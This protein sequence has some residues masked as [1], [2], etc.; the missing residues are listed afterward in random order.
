MRTK[1]FFDLGVEDLKNK[2]IILDIDGTLTHDRLAKLEDKTVAKVQELK[3]HN[4]IYLCSNRNNHDRNK[5]VAKEVGVEYLHTNIRKPRKGIMA[6]VPNHE[7]KDLLVIGDKFLTDGLFA[8]RIGGKF[9]KVKRI[10][11]PNDRLTTRTIN[12][13]D[14]LISKFFK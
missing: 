3:K 6:L 10:A 11:S 12:W 2:L 13:I 4:E 9:I 8:R 14:D 1:F 7:G 5:Q